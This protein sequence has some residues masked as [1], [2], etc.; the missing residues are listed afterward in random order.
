MSQIIYFELSDSILTVEN[1]GKKVNKSNKSYFFAHSSY[2][3]FGLVSKYHLD[4]TR[5]L[6]SSMNLEWS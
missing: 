4:E 1:F 3:R 2:M 5:A 6:G